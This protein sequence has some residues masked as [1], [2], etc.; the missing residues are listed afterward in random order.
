MSP[1]IRGSGGGGGGLTESAADAIYLRLDASNDPLTDQLSIQGGGVDIDHAQATDGDS[2]KY[3][4]TMSSSG[5]V[6]SAQF[7]GYWDDQGTL[8][9]DY[10]DTWAAKIKGTRL[11]ATGAELR[12][13]VIAGIT[14]TDH[15]GHFLPR[16]SITDVGGTPARWDLGGQTTSES[17]ELQWRNLYLDTWVKDEIKPIDSTLRAKDKP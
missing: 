11:G 4:V 7:F 16:H 9:S 12:V 5:N 17:V 2:E 15:W 3:D 13:G 6:G 10:H 14:A 8:V 1:R